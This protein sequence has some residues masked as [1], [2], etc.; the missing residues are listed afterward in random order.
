MKDFVPK[1]ILKGDSSEE[2]AFW[3]DEIAQ[4]CM[5]TWVDMCEEEKLEVNEVTFRSGLQLASLKYTS[6]DDVRETNFDEE[7]NEEM[8]NPSSKEDERPETSHQE[9]ARRVSLILHNAPFKEMIK[10]DCIRACLSVY[11]AL[12]MSNKLIRALIQALME[13]NYYKVQFDE[14]KVNN[15]SFALPSHYASCMACIEF[16]DKDLQLGEECHNRPLYV[17]EI[18][19]SIVSFWI[20]GQRFNQVGQRA[21]GS[22]ALKVMNDDIYKDALFHL[23]DTDTSYNALPGRPWLHASK[24]TIFTLHQCLKYIDENGN[25]K[26]IRGDQNHFHGESVN[27]ADAIFYKSVNFEPNTL[28]QKMTMKRGL[29]ELGDQLLLTFFAFL[30]I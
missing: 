11:D 8:P 9:K 21:M 25:E 29:K 15:V 5:T 16:F 4:C 3:G 2:N 23:I 13:P 30:L 26:P 18:Q 22:I 17:S 19:K 12:Q 27:Y 7:V 20:V 1:G 10:Y 28:V 6:C 14:V 24:S